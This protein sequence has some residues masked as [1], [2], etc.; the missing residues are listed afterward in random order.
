MISDLMIIIKDAKEIKHYSNQ[1]K[2]DGNK[3]F[4]NND[5][6][7]GDDDSDYDKDDDNHDNDNEYVVHHLLHCFQAAY[8]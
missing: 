8:K 7:D 4:Y 1:W 6:D 3:D 2:N 5:D